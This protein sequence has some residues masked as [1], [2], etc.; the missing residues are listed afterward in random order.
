MRLSGASR[1]SMLIDESHADPALQLVDRAQIPFDAQ[2][3]A[4]AQ[5]ALR[6]PNRLWGQSRLSGQAS[7][8]QRL[9][10]PMNWI[11]HEAQ[12]PAQCAS[13]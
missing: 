2:Y 1:H 7:S 13:S 5:D 3:V 6:C 11:S 10:A 12:R 4:L 8:M 9:I